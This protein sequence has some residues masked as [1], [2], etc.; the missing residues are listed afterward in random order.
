[1]KRMMVGPLL[2][3]AA[4]VSPQPQLQPAQPVAP[5]R[6][7]RATAHATATIRIISGVRFGPSYAASVAGADRR[8]SRLTDADGT[9]RPAELLEFQ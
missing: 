9:T 7:T 3:L 4:S 8:S 2:F 1:M 6:H 5:A